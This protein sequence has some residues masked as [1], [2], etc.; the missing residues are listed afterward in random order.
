MEIFVY[1]EGANQVEEG[2]SAADLPELLANRKNVVWVDMEQPT[3]DDE[4]ILSDVFKFHFLTI[5]DCRE[6][7]NQPK[8]EGFAEY[9]YFIFH[10]VSVDTNAANLVTKELD[11]YL[12]PNYV[13][14]YHHENFRSIDK[15]KQQVRATPY[16]C[17]R[18]ADFLLHQ[19]LDNLVDLY[20]PIV[21]DFDYAISA[22]E[23]RVF[24]MTTTNTQILQ[25]IME[26]KRS[27][28][29]LRRLTS[30][31]MEA[32]YRLSHGEFPLISSAHIPFYRD[33]HDHL[34]RISDLSEN[35]RDLIGGLLD[36]HLS[37]IANK[38]NDIMKTL[39]ILSAIMLPLTLIAGIYGMNFDNMPELH[40]R[41]GYFVT[42]AVM[43]SIAV[44]LI[45]YFWQ[46]GWI[47][48]REDGRG[49]DEKD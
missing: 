20:I 49:G 4:K 9:L 11:G 41:N 19:I 3:A 5:E 13:V 1:R 10:G 36:I 25:E 16:S 48:Q 46:K 2:F 18:G 45:F 8:V 17:S 39:A 22:L 29:R 38:T 24:R 27:V 40:S 26:L 37:V 32:L 7:R 14:T 31:Q 34:Q 43:L 28:A 42:L 6:T 35:Y 21:D 33:V 47:F 44:L 15:V 12:G 23:D 30:K